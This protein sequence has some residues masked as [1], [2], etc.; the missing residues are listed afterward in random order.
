MKNYSIS[1]CLVAAAA[2]FLSVPETPKA[3]A[4]DADGAT[5]WSGQKWEYRVLRIDDR[6]QSNTSGARSRGSGSEAKLNELGDQGWELISV[7]NDGTSEP[8][9][10]FKR[11]KK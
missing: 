10:Y 5:A 3:F 4:Q 8:V 1:A 6:R 2:L 7:R 9:F 11:P